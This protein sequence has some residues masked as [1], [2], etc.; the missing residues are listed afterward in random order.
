MIRACWRSA[1]EGLPAGPGRAWHAYPEIRAGVDVPTQRCACDRASVSAALG[2][3]LT[4]SVQGQCRRFCL[5]DGAADLPGRGPSPALI[6]TSLSECARKFSLNIARYCYGCIELEASD[7]AA[8][9]G[10]A[11]HRC[12][13]RR[14]RAAE[15]AD[16]HVRR[17][18]RLVLDRLSR[19]LVSRRRD[20]HSAAP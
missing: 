17:R 14:H 8:I 5:I 18:L 19:Q 10:S 1:S 6:L 11:D 2:T 16:L 4:A 13:S 15:S 3:G 7:G 12:T 20:C 9:G